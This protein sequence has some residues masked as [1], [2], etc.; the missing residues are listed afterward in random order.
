M[1]E[2]ADPLKEAVDLLQ[3]QDDGQ[4]FL[5]PGEGD[6]FNNPLLV[7]THPVEEP[8]GTNGLLELAPGTVFLLRQKD[9]ILANL[10]RT[11]QMGR[12]TELLG[13]LGHPIHI[14]G[15][16]PIGIVADPQ[17]LDHPLA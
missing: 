2:I 6:V 10:R 16:G 4:L 13:E 8:Q 14:Q 5:R 15:N 7:Q 9:L 1:F 12:T 17:I 11:Q 3:R